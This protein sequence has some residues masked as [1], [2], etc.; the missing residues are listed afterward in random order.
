MPRIKESDEVQLCYVSRK[1]RNEIVGPLGDGWI[2][3]AQS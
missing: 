1:G 2:T 3:R